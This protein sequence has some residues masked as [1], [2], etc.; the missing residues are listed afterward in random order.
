MDIL[1]DA[2]I[3]GYAKGTVEAGIRRSNR[4]IMWNW[5]DTL[6]DQFTGFADDF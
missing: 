2:D 6:A 1:G 5:T 3:K 4:P